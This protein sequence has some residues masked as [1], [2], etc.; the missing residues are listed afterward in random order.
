MGSVSQ[1]PENQPP[2]KSNAL[3]ALSWGRR[4]ISHPTG[5]VIHT[6][7]RTRL[8]VLQSSGAFKNHPTNHSPAK[9]VYGS[10]FK[11][12]NSFPISFAES[13]RTRRRVLGDE[14][15]AFL[16]KKKITG[17]S[18]GAHPSASREFAL[19]NRGL[20]DLAYGSLFEETDLP[21]RVIFASL[22]GFQS[23]TAPCEDK[24]DRATFNLVPL[25]SSC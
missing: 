11:I 7:G 19:A 4:P 22:S 20:G 1:N 21:P 3:T 17:Q 15:V 23:P 2:E 13:I 5:G 6:M 9:P 12:T 18:V 25:N 14:F 16:G 8:V 24:K 10:Y